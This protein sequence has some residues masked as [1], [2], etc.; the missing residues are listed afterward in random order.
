MK[1][2]HFFFKVKSKRQWSLSTNTNK[3]KKE[4]K[5]P[6]NDPFDLGYGRG[7]IEGKQV[8]TEGVFWNAPG[9]NLTLS[10]FSMWL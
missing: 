10:C 6:K 8:Y 3:K 1:L 2:K 4:E 5:T 9:L 7:E